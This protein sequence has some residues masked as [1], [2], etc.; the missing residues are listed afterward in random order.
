MT[1]LDYAQFLLAAQRNYTLTYF[2]DHHDS[3]SHDAINRFMSS[4]KLTP[5]LVWDN[6]KDEIDAHE[7]GY[8]IFDDT[9]L[10]KRHS[11]HIDLARRQYSGAA[12]G[13]IEG[14]GLVTCVYVNPE[15]E[16]FW[17]IDYRLFDPETDGKSKHE[18][19]HDMLLHTVHSKQLA[20]T[21]VL[22]DTWYATMKLWKQLERLG[23]LYY[24]PI[25][26]NRQVSLSPETGYQAVCDLTWS[27]VEL[28][29]GR[30]VHLK[31]MPR[32]H[33]VRL[34]RLVSSTGDTDYV[35]TN[36]VSAASAQGAQ[37]VSSLRWK[38][39]QVHREVKQVTG[40]AECQCRKGRI[41]RNHIGCALLVWVRLKALAAKAGTSV[42]QLKQGLLN[43]YM[44]AK[45]RNP[46]ISLQLA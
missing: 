22:M 20:F 15:S 10:D 37:E 35:V 43:D 33:H 40:I 32:G 36:D 39:E 29:Q 7:S 42:Y 30:L 46:T 3:L 38:I 25:R 41:Q 19:V 1:R 4:D 17:L 16:R 24:C 14:I 45:L 23:K 12:K 9:V 21:T 26:S 2:A 6:V 18:H 13:V 28:Q 34:F 44:V 5:R 27:D 8:L 31:K 11:K